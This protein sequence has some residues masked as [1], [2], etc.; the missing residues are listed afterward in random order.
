MSLKSINPNAEL[1]NPDAA[2][3]M[4]INAAKGLQD[5]MKTNLGPKGTI[6][7]LVDGAGGACAIA[8][9]TN[10]GYARRGGARAMRGDGDLLDFARTRRGVDSVDRTTDGDVEIDGRRFE[11]HEGWERAAERDADSKPDGDHDREDGGGAG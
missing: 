4:N 8:S 2:L 7:M 1:M 11:A 10:R 6:K 9:S 5:V 3:F